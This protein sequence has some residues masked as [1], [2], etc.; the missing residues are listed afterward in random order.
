MSRV[1]RLLSTALNAS[2]WDKPHTVCTKSRAGI[3]GICTMLFLWARNAPF[4]GA[5]PHVGHAWAP[6]VYCVTCY[7]TWHDVYDV[8]MLSNVDL[9]LTLGENRFWLRLWARPT[10]PQ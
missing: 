7:V 4:V 10:R 8:I 3:A 2:E 6:D 1:V 9:S 5:A